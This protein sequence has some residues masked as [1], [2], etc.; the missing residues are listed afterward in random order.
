MYHS[1][2][3]KRLPRTTNLSALEVLAL[4][5][6]ARH[7]SLGV[8]SPISSEHSFGI[9]RYLH[10]PPTRELRAPRRRRCSGLQTAA[11]PGARPRQR[12]GEIRD[13]RMAATRPLERCPALG[14]AAWG[15]PL[16]P[17]R[18]DTRERVDSNASNLVVSQLELCAPTQLPIDARLKQCRRAAVEQGA[19]LEGALQQI[20]QRGAENLQSC[21]PAAIAGPR[22]TWT[23]QR[24]TSRAIWPPRRSRRSPAS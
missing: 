7:A 13:E 18:C 10:A 22:F 15:A 24:R 1:R 2:V 5:R 9:A 19:A 17:C 11:Q 8:V 3:A 16:P 20:G 14:D 6:P 21:T 12:L 23:N 4:D